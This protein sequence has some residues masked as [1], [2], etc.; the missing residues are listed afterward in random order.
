MHLPMKLFSRTSFSHVTTAFTLACGLVACGGGGGGGSSST[1]SGV[2]A[3]SYV[4]GSAEHGA[5]TV[6]Q[7]ARTQCGFGAVTR[8]TQLDA[9]AL[10]HAKYMVDLSF[11]TGTPV[12]SHT[13]A[14]GVAGFTGADLGDRAIH[15]GYIYGAVAEILEATSWDYGTQQSFPTMEA[16]GASSMLN[17]MNTV[18]HLSGAMYEGRDVGMGAFMDTKKIT[19]TTWREEYRF[20]ALVGYR[21]T[22]SPIVMGAG[23]IATYPCAGITNI[24][25]RFAP[26]DE[27]PNPFPNSAQLVGPPIYVKVDD[28]QV[29]HNVI[30]TVNRNGVNVSTI[31]LTASNDPNSEILANEVFVIPSSQLLPNSTYQVNLSGSIGALPFTRSFSFST[32]S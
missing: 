22:A 17:L 27:S 7:T 29:L 5:F 11:A 3:A 10:A 20:G 6:L 25:P 14:P 1:G 21:H 32:G 13:E 19:G 23:Q 12:L 28:G 4:P 26:A 16:R 15:Q 24:P 18:Y 30:G 2:T 8:N 31:V 9:A